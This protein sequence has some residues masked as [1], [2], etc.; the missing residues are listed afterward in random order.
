MKEM[1]QKQSSCLHST[2]PR[3][4]ACVPRPVFASL[5]TLFY[6]SWLQSTCA[7][8][9]FRIICVI[10]DIQYR[11]ISNGSRVIWYSRFKEALTVFWKENKQESLYLSHYLWNAIKGR[12]HF[13]GD[14]YIFLSSC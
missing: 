5:L 7:L 8:C 11:Y 2:E 9:L 10:S 1:G 6:Y 4:Q 14:Y 3:L 12:F 13:Q